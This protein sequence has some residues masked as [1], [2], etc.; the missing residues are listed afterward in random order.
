[1]PVRVPPKASDAEPSEIR[2]APAGRLRAIENLQERGVGRP[3]PRQHEPEQP[4]V[5]VLVLAHE[6]IR[7]MKEGKS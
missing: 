5:N 2:T 6:R 4:A 3:E 7:L 1:M